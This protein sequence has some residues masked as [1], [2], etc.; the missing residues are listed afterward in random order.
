MEGIKKG[1]INTSALPGLKN[2]ERYSYLL[3]VR[4]DYSPR[5]LINLMY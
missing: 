3:Q 4:N 1:P 2:V 5:V